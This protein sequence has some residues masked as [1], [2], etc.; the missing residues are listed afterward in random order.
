MNKIENLVRDLIGD[1]EFKLVGSVNT[2][3]FS[4]NSDIDIAVKEKDIEIILDDLRKK[5]ARILE[6]KDYREPD[7]YAE[8]KVFLSGIRTLHIIASYDSKIKRAA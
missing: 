6:T 3:R 2:F 7:D 4:Q 8:Y 1:K 5:G